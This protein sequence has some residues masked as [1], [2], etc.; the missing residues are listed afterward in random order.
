MVA[1]RYPEVRLNGWQALEGLFAELPPSDYYRSL[2][3]ALNVASDS[4]ED[5]EQS[6]GCGAC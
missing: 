2:N 5:P 6:V 1:V 4:F 3:N